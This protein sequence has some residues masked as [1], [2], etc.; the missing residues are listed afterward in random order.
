VLGYKTDSDICVLTGGGR[1][2]CAGD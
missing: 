1:R 2:V